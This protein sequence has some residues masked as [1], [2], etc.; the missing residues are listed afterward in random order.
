VSGERDAANCALLTETLVKLSKQELDR[1]VVAIFHGS[2]YNAYEGLRNFYFPL[3]NILTKADVTLEMYLN[4]FEEAKI[5]NQQLLATLES[6]PISKKDETTFQYECWLRLRE[7]VVRRSNELNSVRS[8]LNA[9]Q[10]DVDKQLKA[11]KKELSDLKEKDKAVQ[12]KLIEAKQI[13][14]D[15]QKSK[16][17]AE[18]QTVE[19]HYFE[20]GQLRKQLNDRKIEPDYQ[21]LF[22]SFLK[23]VEAQLKIRQEELDISI[24]TAKDYVAIGDLIKEYTFVAAYHFDF[25]NDSDNLILVSQG[26]TRP[27]FQKRYTLSYYN[28]FFKAFSSVVEKLDM[29]KGKNRFV[30]ESFSGKYLPASLSSESMQMLAGAASLAF[31]VPGFNLRNAPGNYDYDQMPGK[32]NYNLSGLENVVLELFTAIID[33]PELSMRST[34]NDSVLMDKYLFYSYKNGNYEGTKFN[35]VNQGGDEIDG[36]AAG[37]FVFLSQFPWQRMPNLCG[38]SLSAFGRINQDGYTSMPLLTIGGSWDSQ[39]NAMSVGG[40]GFDEFGQITHINLKD[41]YDRLF[42]AY[43]GVMSFTYAP[44]TYNFAGSIDARNGKTDASFKNCPLGSGRWISLC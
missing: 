42:R 40:I 22:S 11:L 30:D 1:A 33:A 27:F 41:K 20:I 23:Q 29:Q 25:A 10:R 9:K 28:K 38:F 12:G 34:L 2:A 21:T 39:I 13:K 7:V 8:A 24:R 15:D 3:N 6:D 17:Q 18:I 5:K 31:K 36:P 32:R 19:K 37:M 35:L 44:F 14:L 16:L 26:Y 43:G 4:G